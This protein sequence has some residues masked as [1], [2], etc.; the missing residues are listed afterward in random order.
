MVI[1]YIAVGANIEPH[2]N[3]VEAL[4]LLS[5]RIPVVGVST[6]YRSAPLDRPSQADYLNGVVAA[7]TDMGAM[8]LKRRVLQLVESKL[9]R[10]RTAD[11]FAARSIDLDLILYGGDV[12]S[13]ETLI[14]PDPD[15]R[16]RAFV[17]LPLSEVAPGLRLPDTGEALAELTVLNER[18]GLTPDV[19]LTRRV[20][21]RLGL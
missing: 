19:E 7:K 6:F 4:S 21:E 2:R 16:Q 8:R 17:A 18:D 5:K 13:S 3:I 14:L 20:K 1:A 10:V 12:V 15:I 9:G 11:R